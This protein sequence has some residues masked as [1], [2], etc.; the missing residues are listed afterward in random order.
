[1]KS[2]GNITLGYDGKD[3]RGEFNN[4]LTFHIFLG[5]T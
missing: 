2:E 4:L 3:E 1:M 5:L